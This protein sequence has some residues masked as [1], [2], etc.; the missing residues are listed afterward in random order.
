[1]AEPLEV[2]FRV[3]ASVAHEEAVAE[4]LANLAVFQL[5]QRHGKAERWE[6]ARVEGAGGDHFYRVQLRLAGFG[7]RSRVKADLLK[8][9]DELSKEEEP[10]LAARLDAAVAQGFAR[11]PLSHEIDPRWKK[12]GGKT[13]AQEEAAA[14]AAAPT[15][16]A[17]HRLDRAH[18]RT[19]FR[20]SLVMVLVLSV[21]V[22]VAVLWPAFHPAPGPA[23]G[24]T[25]A[26]NGPGASTIYVTLGHPSVSTYSCG[27]GKGVSLESIPWLRSTARVETGEFVIEVRELADGD[28]VGG[29]T[30]KLN[31]TSSNLCAGAPPS[32]YTW[33][34]VIQT[35]TGTN[36][37]SFDYVQGWATVGGAPS[38]D[39]VV[40]NSTINLLIAPGVAGLGYGLFL[41]GV[42]NGPN[43]LGNVTL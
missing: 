32:T 39:P 38:S 15:G 4:L 11:Q 28:V 42:V 37:A 7:A 19:A 40:G 1:M 3:A 24:T 26:S 33:Y 17:L 34:S 23:S 22:A 27:D 18:D 10:A 13:E 20:F 8:I 29:P 14:A 21:A 35:P 5:Q 12:A 16:A 6:I 2:G 31:V 25:G 36:V 43:V 9:L 30:A 41:Y